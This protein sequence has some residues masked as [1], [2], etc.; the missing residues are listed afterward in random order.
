MILGEFISEQR[1]RCDVRVSGWKE[2]VHLLAEILAEDLGVG[3][4][5]L[6]EALVA[7]ER[8]GMTTIGK[9]VGMPHAK[10]AAVLA[11]V[12]AFVQL[13]E[14]LST[15]TPDEIPVDLFV[16]YLSPTVDADLAP[17]ANVV[18]QMRDEVFLRA[19][20]SSQTPAAIHALLSRRN[21]AP[22]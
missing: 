18:R 17:L 4:A 11:P 3:A 9:G 1:I 2:T 12:G 19:L 8:L 14:P 22:R 10:S 5:I 20:R 13:R 15:P 16:C 6:K 7:R 21:I